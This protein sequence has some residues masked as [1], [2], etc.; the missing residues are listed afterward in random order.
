MMQKEG[1]SIS[2]EDISVVLQRF[3][4]FIPFVVDLLKKTI[5]PSQF[6]AVVQEMVFATTILALLYE[7]AHVQDVT[8]DWNALMK[9]TKTGLTNPREYQMLWRH[10]AYCDPLLEKLED[11]AQPL[12]DD[13]DLECELEAFPNVSNEASAEGRLC[14]GCAN[15]N[16]PPRRKR[17]PW[18]AAEDK[19]LFAAVQ[20][21]GEK[22][23]GL[24]L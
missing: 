23:I 3:V 17:K 12:D 7:V 24:T 21:Y 11:D 20:R 2:E 16:L 4:S 5:I 18:S 22:G 6:F 15:I 13:S 14:E 1:A 9:H 8:I 19:E 10:L